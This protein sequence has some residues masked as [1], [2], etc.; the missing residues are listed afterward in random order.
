MIFTAK[1]KIFTVII[2][3]IGALMNQ[4]HHHHHFSYNEEERRRN[5]NPEKI[6]L[7]AGLKEGMVFADIGCNDGFFSIPA[8][9]IVGKNGKVIAND[10]NDEALESLRQ[11]FINEGFSSYEIIVGPAE[12][13]K[14]EAN[15]IDF[16]FFGIVLH[17]FNNPLKVLDI[18]KSA[19][20][21]NGIV[22]D[23]DWRKDSQKN[24]PP[25]NIRLSIEDVKNMSETQGLK[26]LS[27]KNLDENFYQVIISKN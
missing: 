23:F 26:V 14:L 3:K 27:S 8:S 13:L 10:V 11:K 19:L 9:R 16:I 7:E 1:F 24:G 15:S 5:Q 12:N 21:D 18:S 4:W 25:T 17:D 6:L 20:T 22:Y 2:E